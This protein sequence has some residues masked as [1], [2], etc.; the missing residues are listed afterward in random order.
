[1]KSILVC[2]EMRHFSYSCCWVIFIYLNG[3]SFGTCFPYFLEPRMFDS[4]CPF[5]RSGMWAECSCC[6]CSWI[7]IICQKVTG[8]FKASLLKF[9]LVWKK[10]KLFLFKLSEAVHFLPALKLC[11]F[12][13][14]MLKLLYWTQHVSLFSW[15]DEESKFNITDSSAGSEDGI[16]FGELICWRFVCSPLL[17]MEPTCWISWVCVTGYWMEQLWSSLRYLPCT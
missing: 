4:T 12:C 14:L 11:L 6:Q 13:G 10:R 5:H 16:Y 8:I 17:N 9:Q 7:L 2:K 3:V 1:M 15:T